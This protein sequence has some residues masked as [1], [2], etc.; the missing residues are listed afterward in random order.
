MT[1]ARSDARLFHPDRAGLG[2]DRLTG[3]GNTFAF[4]ADLGRSV[5]A[6]AT[7]GDPGERAGRTTLLLIDVDDF[8]AVN[9]RLGP[10]G[11]DD[12]L[13]G[14]AVLLA[15]FADDQGIGRARAYRFGGDNF[16][17][18]APGAGSQEA[19][20]LA[21]ACLERVRARH[22]RMAADLEVPVTVSIGLACYPDS[23]RSAGGLILAATQAVQQAKRNGGNGVVLRTRSDAGDPES[24]DLVGTLVQHVLET[25][26]LLEEAQVLAYTDPI[27][28]LPNQRAAREYVTRECQRSGRYGRTFAVVLVDGDNLRNY[29]TQFGYLAGNRMIRRLGDFLSTQV[30]ASDF[31]ARWLSGD[32]FLIVMPETGRRE[33]LATAERIRA[34][35]A[36]DSV[37]WALPV[38]ISA[39]IAVFP[40]D[41]QDPEMLCQLAEVA[42]HVAK[43]RGK[44]RVLAWEAELDAGAPAGSGSG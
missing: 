14:V 36:A 32:E 26:R 34:A 1:E 33:A 40:Y 15:D 11:G 17:L 43:A 6:A 35:V 27:S 41:A 3:L 24:A 9:A 22:F 20:R 10:R 7:A 13:R 5:A 25:V 38:T 12:L 39:G 42:N 16:C 21:R 2:E 31:V 18:I 23:A 19:R 44:N 30:R 28:G 29:N 37:D 4:L 8:R